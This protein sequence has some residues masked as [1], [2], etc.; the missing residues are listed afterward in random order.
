HHPQTQSR[1]SYDADALYAIFHVH[2]RYVKSLCTHYQDM[3]CND[4]CVELFLQ[5]KID[6]GYFNFEINC[7]GTMLLY[8][9][10]DP[11]I[12]G[13][14]FRRFTKVAAEHAIMIQIA[15]TMPK[16]TPV[17]IAEPVEWSLALR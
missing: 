4:S 9:I 13:K 17:E 1:L 7:G 6:R 5:P 8:Y 14:S 16:T 15:T 10:E 11:T 3:V 12:V 2:D